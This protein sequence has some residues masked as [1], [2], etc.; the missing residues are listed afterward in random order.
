MWVQQ[1]E[2]GCLCLD[3]Q[4]IYNELSLCGGTTQNHGSH[5]WTLGNGVTAVCETKR[6]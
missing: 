1:K 5:L 4:C 3:S 6:P 2:K